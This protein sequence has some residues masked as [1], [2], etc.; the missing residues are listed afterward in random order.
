MIRANAQVH[1]TFAV[2]IDADYLMRFGIGASMYN[3]EKW[4]F[5]K[6]PDILKKEIIMKKADDESILG[7]S[8]RFEFMARNI[9]TPYGA[10]IQYF[11]E[12][13]MAN[14]WLQIPVVE[15]TVYV[16]LDAKGY[17]TAFRNEAHPWENKSVFT[18]MGRL[19]LNF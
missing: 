6:H 8:G 16:R 19:I 12:A 4:T 1:Y 15:N 3:V 9:V 7:I 5:D 13:L 18:P 10:S 14:L 11:D 17:F 2:S